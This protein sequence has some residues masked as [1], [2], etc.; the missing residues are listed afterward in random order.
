MLPLNDA[1]RPGGSPVA[2]RLLNGPVPAAMSMVPLKPAWLTV[3]AEEDKVPN[4]GAALTV[5]VYVTVL[6]APA[7][8]STLKLMVLKVPAVVGVP[9]TVMVLPLNDAV[10]PGGKLLAVRLLNGPVPA[11]MPMVP[12]KPAWLTVQAVDDNA[13]SAG[14]GSP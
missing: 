8:S 14:T 9:L 2:A 1:V 6:V 10:R 3:Q 13:P 7:A 4:V 5:M 12:L 11:A